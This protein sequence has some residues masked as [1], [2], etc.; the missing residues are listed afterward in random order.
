MHSS[1]LLYIHREFI[2]IPLFFLIIIH[3][4]AASDAD[5]KKLQ[6]QR[7]LMADS[8]KTKAMIQK[9]RQ[10]KTL[11]EQ[12]LSAKLNRRVNVQGEINNLTA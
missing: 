1:L 4:R 3:C 6:I 11:V 2:K 8:A 9:T 10:L 5:S 7:E 12:A